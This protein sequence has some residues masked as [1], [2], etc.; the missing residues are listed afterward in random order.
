MQR[1]VGKRQGAAVTGGDRA[2]DAAPPRSLTVAPVGVVAGQVTSII[3]GILTEMAGK[4]GPGCSAVDVACWPGLSEARAQRAG[5]CGPLGS[6]RRCG[7]VWQHRP[8]DEPLLLG[9]AAKVRTLLGWT[10]RHNLTECVGR[11]LRYWRRRVAGDWRRSLNYCLS[12]VNRTRK[13][14]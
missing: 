6:G 2:V 14:F 7:H 10:P 8:G 3:E 11:V 9:D 13:S 4:D 12:F 1:V 5:A